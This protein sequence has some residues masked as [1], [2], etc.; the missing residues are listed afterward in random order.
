[1]AIELNEVEHA[2]RKTYT[3]NDVFSAVAGETF[4]IEIG[5]NKKLNV[6][7]PEGENWVAISINIAIDSVSV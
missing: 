6:E 2:A 4:E 5:G 7:V 3:A 1:M